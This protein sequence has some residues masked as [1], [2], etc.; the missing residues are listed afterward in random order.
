MLLDDKRQ[1]TSGSYFPGLNILKKKK[2]HYHM[3]LFENEH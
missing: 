1:Q 2:N 3:N